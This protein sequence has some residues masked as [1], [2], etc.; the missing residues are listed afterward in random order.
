MEAKRQKMNKEI[1]NED[2]IIGEVI[3]IPGV[4]F[5]NNYLIPV[6]VKK[7]TTLYNLPGY[8]INDEYY[9]AMHVLHYYISGRV[10]EIEVGLESLPF[11]ADTAEKE[12]FRF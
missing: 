4:T 11:K 5:P 3:N 7:I 12:I 10:K 2:G 9:I 6:T 1:K 8:V